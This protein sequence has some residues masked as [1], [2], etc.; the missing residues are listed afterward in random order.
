MN[1]V[2]RKK[3]DSEAETEQTTRQTA[4]RGGGPWGQRLA[5]LCHKPRNAKNCHNRQKLDEAR[6]TS[7]LKPS[8]V[9]P[10]P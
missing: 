1:A 4:M 10:P 2:S 8:K 6:H 9:P 7:S 5:L 3:E